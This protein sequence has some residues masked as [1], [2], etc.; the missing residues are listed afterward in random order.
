MLEPG[1]K[2]LTPSGTVNQDCRSDSPTLLRHHRGTRPHR[3]SAYIPHMRFLL[4]FLSLCCVASRLPAQSN[5]ELISNDHYTRSHDYD[6][7]HQR[8]EVSNF[9]WDST[10]FDGRV[11]TTLVARRP[12]LDS[13]VL[14]A[15]EKLGLKA[16]TAGSG[17]LAVL[18]AAQG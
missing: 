10:S 16:V 9:N 14:D 4:G 6:L 7:V 2:V 18:T 11:A 8:I 3:L 12:G 15:G 13:V 5:A 17:G 1:A